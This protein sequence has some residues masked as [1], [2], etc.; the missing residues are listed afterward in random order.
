MST[1][2]TT[3]DTDVKAFPSTEITSDRGDPGVSDGAARFYQVDLD[4]V[5]RK[6]SGVHIYMYVCFP[7]AGLSSFMVSS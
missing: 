5:Q 6:L 4:K 2:K 3:F 7:L 1:L